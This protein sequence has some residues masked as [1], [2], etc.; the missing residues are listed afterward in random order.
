M[1]GGFLV[2]G[3]GLATIGMVVGVVV[4]TML[5]NCA[6]KSPSIPV[7]RQTPTSPEEDLDIDPHLPRP[8]DPPLDEWRQT[9]VV[10]RYSYR[11]IITRSIIGGGFLSALAVPLIGA[12]GLPPSRSRQL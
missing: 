12:I 10:R 2:L 5:V 3:L 9:D 6:I 11:Q 8:D 4:G 7:A 1:I